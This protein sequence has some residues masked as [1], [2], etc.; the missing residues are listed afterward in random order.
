MNKEIYR[1][2]IIHGVLCL[3]NR[4]TVLVVLS[5]KVLGLPRCLEIVNSYIED[6]EEKNA[7]HRT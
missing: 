7:P 3:V 4:S 1:I 6:A 5:I 2:E